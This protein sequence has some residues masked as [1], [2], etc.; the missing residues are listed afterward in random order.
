MKK[1]SLILTLTLIFAFGLLFSQ[2]QKGLIQ[3]TT[4]SIIT[5]PVSKTEFLD[6]SAFPVKLFNAQYD[7][8]KGNIPYFSDSKTILKNNTVKVS[9][10]NIKT[11]VL[12]AEV[13][14]KLMTLYKSHLTAEFSIETYYA[15]SAKRLR[16]FCKN[17]T[18]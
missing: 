5:N 14:Q 4:S 10:S 3:E 7:L 9:L 16:C 8:K 18:L 15:Q 13:S 1:T 17:Y 11:V 12:S 2:K 6:N